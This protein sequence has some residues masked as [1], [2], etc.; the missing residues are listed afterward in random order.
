MTNIKFHALRHTYAT[1]LFEEGVQIKTVQSLLGHSDININTTT[2]IY[3]HVTSDIKNNA[4]EKLNYIFNFQN[5][6]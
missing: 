6:F 4:I 1:R 3:T 5:R 2:N